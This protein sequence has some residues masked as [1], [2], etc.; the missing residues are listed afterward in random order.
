MCA[1]VIKQSL[2]MQKVLTDSVL[3]KRV[4]AELKVIEEIEQPYAKKTYRG[5]FFPEEKVLSALLY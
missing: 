5:S 1:W 4:K 3:T 2:S